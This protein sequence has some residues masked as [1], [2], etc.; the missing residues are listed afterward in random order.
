MISTTNYL[1]MTS[2]QIEEAIAKNSILLFYVGAVEQHGAHLPTGTDIYLPQT[3]L[4]RIAKKNWGR[5][6]TN[7]KF[8]IQIITTFWR[9]TTF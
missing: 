7:N 9:W 1:E 2:M 5:C 3:L 6:C 4:E 8:R